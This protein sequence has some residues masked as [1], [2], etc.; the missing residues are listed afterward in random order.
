LTKNGHG[1]D[2]ENRHEESSS[3]NSI[4]DEEESFLAYLYVP[5]IDEKF[6]ET[7]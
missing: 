7:A 4:V 3:S 5:G 1:V 6:V 2:C